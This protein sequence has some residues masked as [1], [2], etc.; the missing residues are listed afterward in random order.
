MAKHHGRVKASECHAV[1]TG[2][3]SRAQSHDQQRA[4]KRHGEAVAAAELAAYVANIRFEDTKA[5][6]TGA[7]RAAVAKQRA[8]DLACA[9]YAAGHTMPMAKS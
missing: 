4:Q 5:A 3:L 1:E 2:F 8:V 6:A 9:L 7:A